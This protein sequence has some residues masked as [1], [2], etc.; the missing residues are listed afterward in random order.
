MTAVVVLLVVVVAMPPA[1]VD[2]VVEPP[3]PVVV[4][5][6]VLCGLEEQAARELSANE[7]SREA[8]I[9]GPCYHRAAAV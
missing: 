2:V 9:M 7:A 3:L 6:L 1:P 8:R 4:P 5:V